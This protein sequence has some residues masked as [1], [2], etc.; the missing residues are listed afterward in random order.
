LPIDLTEIKYVNKEFELE[1]SLPENTFLIEGIQ[2]IKRGISTDIFKFIPS[3]K[4]IVFLEKYANSVSTA[5]KPSEAENTDSIPDNDT[6]N[7]KDDMVDK[8][9][10]EKTKT[11]DKSVEVSTKSKKEKS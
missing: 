5:E 2:I 10:K 3:L 6:S 1:I 11:D 9:K 8:C 7:D 4:S